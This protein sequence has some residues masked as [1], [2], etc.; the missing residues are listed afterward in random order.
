MP[1]SYPSRTHPEGETTGTAERPAQHL[2]GPVLTFDLEAELAQLHREEAWRRGDHNAITLTKGPDLRIVLVAMK[3]G[4]R[5]PSHQTAA[6]IVIQALAG[7]VQV[8]LPDQL[9]TLPQGHLLTL[10]AGI[11]HSIEAL[12][13]ST[14]LLTV[15]WQGNAAGSP[16]PL[17]SAS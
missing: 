7:R 13:E 4:A 15:A 9:I 11:P 1:E 10:E 12:S 16:T 17:D 3:E 2:A 5:L 6:R 8:Q 14:F